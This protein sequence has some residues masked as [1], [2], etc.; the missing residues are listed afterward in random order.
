MELIY[1][2]TDKIM[3]KQSIQEIKI[4]QK[5]SLFLITL[6]YWIFDLDIHIQWYTMSCYLFIE[7]SMLRQTEHSYDYAI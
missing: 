6:Q 4:N 2:C 1:V 5:D 7:I 3:T